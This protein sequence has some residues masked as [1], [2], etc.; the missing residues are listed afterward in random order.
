MK[1]SYSAFLFLMYL[2]TACQQQQQQQQPKPLTNAELKEK[3]N[4]LAHEFI[5]VDTHVDIPYR[6]REKMA[7][8]SQQTADGDFDYV[9]AKAGGLDATFI[10]IYV[11]A[12]YERK[13]AKAMADPCAWSLA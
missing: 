7:D 5:I 9:R 3:A 10:S 11:P 2:I 4:R 8:I 6:L 13:G 1:S 12:L